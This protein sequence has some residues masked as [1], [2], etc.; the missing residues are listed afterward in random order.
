MADSNQTSQDSSVLDFSTVPEPLLSFN[1]VD[2]NDDVA[3]GSNQSTNRKMAEAVP[4]NPIP[5]RKEQVTIPDPLTLDPATKASLVLLRKACEAAG[6]ECTIPM[7][8]QIKSIGQEELIAESHLVWYVRG[9]VMAHSSRVLPSVHDAIA[10]LK[11][12]LRHLMNVTNNA[13]RTTTSLEK[14]AAG[15]KLNLSEATSG[16]RDMFDSTLKAVAASYEDKLAHRA[17]VG[18][19]PVKEK[20]V[21]IVTN[22]Q[23]PPVLEVSPS[24]TAE[25]VA[26]AAIMKT[27]ADA[28]ALIKDKTEMLKSIGLSAM[29]IR[30]LNEEALNKVLPNE[31]YSEIAKLKLTPANKATVHQVIVGNLKQYIASLGAGTSASK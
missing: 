22:A 9:I 4:P 23:P 14:A 26:A 29:V 20:K 3:T 13:S 16:V 30:E 17:E 27:V 5:V 18:E 19:V 11:T 8:N 31:L 15:L 7:I 2:S 1:L 25:N 6:I 28:S 10:E 21:A 12:E 24:V